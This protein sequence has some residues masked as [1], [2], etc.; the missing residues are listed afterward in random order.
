[1]SQVL[2]EEEE[3]AA[4]WVMADLLL[5]VQNEDWSFV[6][7]AENRKNEE[8][9]REGRE[10]SLSIPSLSVRLCCLL[11]QALPLLCECSRNI[12]LGGGSE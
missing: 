2:L 1:M 12:F 10:N 9:S 4:N 3:M 6:G 5:R 8:R 11:P 7:N